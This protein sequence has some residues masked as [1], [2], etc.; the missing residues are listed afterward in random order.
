MDTP[1]RDT[2]SREAHE[3]VWCQEDTLLLAIR[4]SCLDHHGQGVS[5]LQMLVL[6]ACEAVRPC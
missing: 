4:L 5:N 6:F 2:L 3:F 1:L